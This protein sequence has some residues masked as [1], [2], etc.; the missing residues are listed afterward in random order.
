MSWTT[1]RGHRPVG[2]PVYERPIGDQDATLDH[3]AQQCS[4]GTVYDCA[5][6]AALV[7]D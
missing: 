7:V 4:C 6:V 3:I 2:P 5:H 1:V